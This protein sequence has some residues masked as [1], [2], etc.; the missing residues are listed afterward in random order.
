MSAPVPTIP[1]TLITIPGSPLPNGVEWS[2]PYVSGS[3]ESD[4]TQQEQISDWQ[5][6][7]LEVSWSL[8]PLTYDQAASWVVFFKALRGRVNVFQLGDP[9]GQNPQGTEAGS[10]VVSGSNQTGFSVVTS[11]WTPSCTFVAGDYIQ[12]GYR[13]YQITVNNA[14]DT[15]GHATL[16]IWPQ[17]RYD[18][19]NATLQTPPD[20]AVITFEDT[21][22]LFRM[23]DTQQKYSITTDKMYK[24]QFQAREAL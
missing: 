16:A 18:L 17:L 6:G 8:A 1:W 24:I 5:S 10:P 14:A 4:F 23:K 12:I 21:V 3:T 19:W 20:Q 13:L 7:M 2:T 15:G 9:L 11:G 22:G